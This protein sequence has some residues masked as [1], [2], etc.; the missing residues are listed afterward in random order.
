[1]QGRRGCWLLLV[2]V[3][4]LMGES[5]T[6]SATRQVILCAGAFQSPQLLELSG[7]GDASLLK[8]KGINLLYENPNVGKNLQDHVYVP[9]GFE[10]AP[11][12]VTFES[13]RNETN[14]AEAVAE[15]TVNHTGPFG[16]RNFEC[17][18][19]V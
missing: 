1:M 4:L 8:S 12:E 18:Y 10:A 5:Y 13:L 9:L 3:S 17:V 6:V 2:L 11:G 15:Y 16:L 7:I 14:L 19:F